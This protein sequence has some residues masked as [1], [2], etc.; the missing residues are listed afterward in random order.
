MSSLIEMII[1]TVVPEKN[2][3]DS[4][5]VFLQLSPLG[6]RNGPSEDENVKS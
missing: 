5:N 6:E 1:E 2:I 3:S 4:D